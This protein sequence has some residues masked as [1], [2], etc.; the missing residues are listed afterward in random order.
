VPPCDRRGILHIRAAADARKTALTGPSNVDRGRGAASDPTTAE[1]RRAGAAL[2]LVAAVAL[3]DGGGIGSRMEHGA[4]RALSSGA[5]PGAEPEVRRG[6]RLSKNRASCLSAQSASARPAAVANQRWRKGLRDA[7]GVK[8][9]GRGPRCPPLAPFL[10][11]A[12]A[13]WACWAYR[14]R[15]PLA[16]PAPRVRQAAARPCSPGRPSPSVPLHHGRHRGLE[17]QTSFFGGKNAVDVLQTQ[18]I[19]YVKSTFSQRAVCEI[20]GSWS[21]RRSEAGGQ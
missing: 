6:A 3:F 12:G 15:S 13:R 1:L 10:A 11:A 16:S 8:V 17:A 20:W 21:T 19:D 5:G 9:A 2:W 18:G 14:S 4:S 7:Q